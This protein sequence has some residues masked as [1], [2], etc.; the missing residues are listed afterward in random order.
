MIVKEID[1]N[2]YDVSEY[3]RLQM[4]LLDKNGIIRIKKEFHIVD[5]LAAKAL[6]DIDIM[7]S[8][9]IILDIRKD[10]IIIDS[11]KDIQVFFIFVNHRPQTR[12]TI[13]NNN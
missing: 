10:V 6:V 1:V 4:Y 5:D 12:V 7:K 8:K 11:C 9:D 2:M 13:F 3:I